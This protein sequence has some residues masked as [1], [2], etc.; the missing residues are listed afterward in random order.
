MI[1]DISN[2]VYTK[3]KESVTTGS[4][5][6]RRPTIDPSFPCVVLSFSTQT[7]SSSVDSSGE[8]HNFI[9]V[10]LDIYSQSQKFNSEILTL[11]REVDS[12]LADFYKLERTIDEEMENINPDIYR[13][14][15]RYDGIVSSDSVIFRR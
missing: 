1:V 13:W 12:I 14:V 2:E 6:K 7:E 5:Y 11:R 9:T 4:V 10:N 3:L 8:T 15:M